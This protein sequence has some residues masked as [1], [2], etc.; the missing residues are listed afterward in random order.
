M[1]TSHDASP[2]GPGQPATRG[3]EP[4][5][6]LRAV[7]RR[8]GA[9]IAL[10]GVSLD[11]HRG[12]V[13]CV[14]G[15]NGAG[16]STLIAMLAGMQQPDTGQIELHGVPTV[17]QGPAVSRRH[18]IRVVYQHSMLVP[19]MTVA[20]NFQLG[21]GATA[22]HALDDARNPGRRHAT[23]DVTALV[24]ELRERH[25]FEGEA[26]TLA[27]EL[28]LGARQFL[29]IERA[30]A[31]M[32]SVLVLDEPTSL[33]AAHHRDA[34]YANI[35]AFSSRGGSVVYVT[36][37]LSEV[38]RLADR[39]TVLRA[40]TVVDRIDPSMLH[41]SHA[42]KSE[43]T[44]ASLRGRIVSAMFGE[45]PMGERQ[46]EH[47]P[48]SAEYDLALPPRSQSPQS[49][50][51]RL[52]GVTVEGP[53]FGTVS[54]GPPE[55]RAPLTGVDLALQ[56]G[57]VMGIAGIEG[58]GQR[59]LARVIAGE[60]PCTRG[61]IFLDSTPIHHRT[62]AQRQRLGIVY[63]PEDRLGEGIIG[64]MSVAL[65]AIATHIGRRP[66]WKGLRMQ[67]DTVRAHAQRL[68][69]HAG[70]RPD[71]P[72]VPAGT[73]SGGNVQKLLLARA[74]DQ[75]PRV[76]VCHQPTHGLD[77]YTAKRIRDE[78]RQLADQGTAVLVLSQDLDELMHLSDRIAVLAGGTLT[79]PL[80]TGDRQTRARLT[81]LLAEVTA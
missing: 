6:R 64:S 31:E 44:G 73:L 34:L 25:G 24:N 43:V 20:E 50:V 4:V 42:W 37:K 74:I 15:E 67:R 39:I 75:A 71:D 23:R 12:E 29:E 17:I 14:L 8:F 47:L 16:K 45:N 49:P 56:P 35:A 26:Q 61:Q 80:M 54:T 7:G 3:E 27:S 57:E 40:G 46:A 11:I 5:I 70:I 52:T 38:Q 22:G 10:D 2:I 58:H 63:V 48:P 81:S 78:L 65:N 9:V 66:F 30:F 41:D 69:T 60:I 51:L 62:V 79:S 19:T 36:H 59:E 68:I 21:L 55:R 76:L 13:H 1:V 53:R 33:L 32:P 28:S 18:G 72:A 77:L